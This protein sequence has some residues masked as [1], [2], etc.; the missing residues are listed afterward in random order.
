MVV[1]NN[2][3]LHDR[4]VHLKGQGLAKHREYWHDV[5]G[6][7]YRMTNI[8]AA[9]GLA[10]LEQASKFIKAKQDVASWYMHYLKDLPLKF[11]TPVGN[12]VHTFWMCSILTE[13]E[14]TRA[15]L[16]EYLKNCGIETRPTFYPIHTMPMYA[17]KYESFPVAE[18][19]SRRGINLPSYPTLTKDD[20]YRISEEIAV[21]FN[22]K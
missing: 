11:H 12:V 5:I 16:R 13:N 20:I 10:Q 8:Q 17:Q 6:F 2:N 1:T 9:I 21:F 7:N 3:T 15:A 22:K 18:D 19:I 4:A 14:Q